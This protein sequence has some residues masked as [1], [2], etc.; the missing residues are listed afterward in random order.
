VK[1]INAHPYGL[2]SSKTL[3]E[4]ERRIH[5]SLPQDYR[6][7]LLEYNGGQPVPSFFWIKPG[8]DGSAIYQFYGL[9]DGPKHLSIDTYA[10]QERYGI[11]SSMLPIGDDGLGNFICIGTSPVN[12]GNIYFLDH[13]LHPYQ[14]PDSPEGITKLAD[15]FTGFLV[16]LTESPDE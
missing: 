14:F 12:Q 2:V 15:S 3:E 10:G 16:C 13:D 5:F 8:K 4:F 7:F 11:P 6:A 9:H 1:I